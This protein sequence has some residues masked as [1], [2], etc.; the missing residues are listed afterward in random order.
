MNESN[1]GNFTREIFFNLKILQT[2]FKSSFWV[3]KMKID[4]FFFLW[5]CGL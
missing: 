2:D 5:L 4:F 1:F 3:M